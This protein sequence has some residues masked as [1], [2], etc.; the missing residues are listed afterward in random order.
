MTFCMSDS[1][2]A[3]VTSSGI[4]PAPN[5][6]STGAPCCPV[7]VSLPLMITA[8]T[9]SSARAA[10]PAACCLCPLAQA[11]RPFTQ[12]GSATSVSLFL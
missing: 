4:A 10:M 3:V 8:A 1:A 9:T 6:S 2:D 5:M 11:P 12:F 7:S